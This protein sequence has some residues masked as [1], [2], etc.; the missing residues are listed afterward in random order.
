MIDD[1]PSTAIL[2]QLRGLGF[3]IQGFGLGFGVWGILGLWI[4]GAPGLSGQLGSALYKPP[5][6]GLGL[7]LQSVLGE[8]DGVLHTRL[9]DVP[10]KGAFT[11]PL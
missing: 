10:C 1:E 5:K 6:A 4:P 7:F 11:G 9:W 8:H 2:Q 3:R